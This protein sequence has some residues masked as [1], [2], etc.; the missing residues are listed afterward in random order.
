MRPLRTPLP[1]LATLIALLATP[2]TATA[3]AT[4]NTNS[5]VP[6][7]LEAGTTLGSPP[8]ARCANGFNVRG[9][10]LISTR[11]ANTTDPVTGPGGGQIGPIT[12]IRD[13]YAV[14]KV[15]DPTKWN[16]LPRI[17]GSATPITG[18]AEAPIG[19]RVCA[20]SALQGWQCGTLQAKN[21]TVHH[22]SGSITGLTRTNLCAQPGNDWLPVVSG[23]QA[24]GHLIGASGG[25]GTCTSYFYPIN[26]ILQAEAF[27][28]VT[29]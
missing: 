20:G 9:H 19:A 11:C 8:N 21:Q 26:R 14:V 5:P 3:T 24:Q 25:S 6:T 10:L 29:A 4:N 22:P 1:A 17:V 2:A 23:S 18:S 16:Q 15:Q 27:T 13:T 12:R 28:L 7:P